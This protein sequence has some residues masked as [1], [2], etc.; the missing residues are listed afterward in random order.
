MKAHSWLYMCVLWLV[1]QEETMRC[2]MYDLPGML[3]LRE[4][5]DLLCVRAFLLIYFE[6]SKKPC[7]LPS[8]RNCTM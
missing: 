7:I 1:E 6:T 4:N 5:K 8:L 2:M 3:A